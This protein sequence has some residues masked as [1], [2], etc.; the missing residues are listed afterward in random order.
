MGSGENGSPVVS[1]PR[2]VEE[3]VSISSGAVILLLQQM[4]E[5]IA[6]ENTLST[7]PA[8]TDPVI[9]TKHYSMP[10]HFSS[11]SVNGQWG[12]W[13]SSGQ[14]SKTCGGGSQYQSR[15]C[16][17]PAPAKGGNYCQGEHSKYISCNNNECK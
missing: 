13:R 9:L 6:R 14:C 10:Q 17:S 4:V 16:D 1:A 12:E 2:P 3:E 8:T 5:N 11:G 7:D 15:R